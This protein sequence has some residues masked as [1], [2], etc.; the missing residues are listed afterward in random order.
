MST[1]SIKEIRW[2]MVRKEKAKQNIGFLKLIKKHDI[3]VDYYE[4]DDNFENWKKLE[5]NGNNP[6]K[7]LPC[8]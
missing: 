2:F 1:D 5:L 6:P 8:N 3:G 7:E 4:G